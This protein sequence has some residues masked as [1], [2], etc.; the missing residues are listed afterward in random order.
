[1]SVL[2]VSLSEFRKLPLNKQQ[3]MRLQVCTTAGIVDG[4]SLS[5][6]ILE[7]IYVNSL[8]NMPVTLVD[9]NRRYSRPAKRFETSTNAIVYEFLNTDAVCMIERSGISAVF[10][11]DI[12][13]EIAAARKTLSLDGDLNEVLISNMLSVP[14]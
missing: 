3:A 11:S 8:N 12:Y 1:M 13:K 7:Y 5:T 14:I 4:L 10:S 2:N 6:R 9:I